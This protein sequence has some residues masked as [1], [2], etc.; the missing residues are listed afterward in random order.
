MMYSNS[1]LTPPQHDM[2]NAGLAV[3]RAHMNSTVRGERKLNFA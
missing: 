2:S 1:P 3:S